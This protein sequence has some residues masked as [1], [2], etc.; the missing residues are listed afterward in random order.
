MLV[1]THTD[2]PGKLEG[3]DE[4]KLATDY[5]M[6][7]ITLVH[8]WNA[9]HGDDIIEL[10]EIHRSGVAASSG[11]TQTVN[12]AVRK[13]QDKIK[14]RFELTKRQPADEP[15]TCCSMSVTAFRELCR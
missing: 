12:K 11:L 8:R 6:L 10:R 3:L 7:K 15:I 4:A 2:K 14:A 5:P 13:I 9:L 1:V